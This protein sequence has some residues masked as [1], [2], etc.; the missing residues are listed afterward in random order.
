MLC[1][2]TLLPHGQHSKVQ[3]GHRRA[4]NKSGPILP[5]HLPFIPAT[6]SVKSSA[7]ISLLEGLLETERS[8]SNSRIVAL[9]VDMSA[10]GVLF[11]E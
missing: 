10:F 2:P 6:V 1:H 9:T 3:K 5:C 7:L 11:I 4:T 8:V